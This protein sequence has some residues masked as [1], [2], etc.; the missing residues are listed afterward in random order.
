[1]FTSCYSN[2][3]PSLKPNSLSR[4]SF[5]LSAEPALETKK[6]D[7]GSHIADV[8]LRIVIPCKGRKDTRN[9]LLL[10]T[11][12]SG[13]LDIISRRASGEQAGLHGTRVDY[14]RVRAASAFAQKRWRNDPPS[15]PHTSCVYTFGR[16]LG[17]FFVT[18]ELER[19]DS[20]LH[21]I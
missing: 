1:M 13:K 4:I 18:Q 15:A 6:R 5:V 12:S 14:A 17:I 9:N 19:N 10:S 7:F 8:E 11:L 3:R 16:H 20:T 21:E 2:P